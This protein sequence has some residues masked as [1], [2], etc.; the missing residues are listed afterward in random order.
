MTKMGLLACAMS[1]AWLL[2]SLPANAQLTEGFDDF[3][4]LVSPAGGWLV[5][6]NS[7]PV[8][9]FTWGQGDTAS[10]GEGFTSQS[11]ADN[12]FA[13][14]NFNAGGASAAVSDWLITPAITIQN[15]TIISFYTRESPVNVNDQTFPND[16]QVRLSLTGT[17][18]GSSAT[19]VGDFTTL[20]L[21]VNPTFSTTVTTGYPQ[22]WTRFNITISGVPTP[23]SGEI[24]FRYFL[25][26]NFT[27]GTGI[28]I[29][30][31][32]VTTVP[33]PSRLALLALGGLGLVFFK[34]REW[35]LIKR[36]ALPRAY[37][38]FTFIGRASPDRAGARPYHPAGRAGAC[39]ASRYT[40]IAQRCVSCLPS[41][42][43]GM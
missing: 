36:P 27:Q 17:D 22:N 33:E 40:R 12:S 11:G 2:S 1:I 25:Q 19:S 31:L 16:L 43:P 26:S 24:G 6:N 14:V 32:S 4:A 15:G 10:N 20:L 13:G 3:P 8:G 28:G 7:Q 5:I 23:T 29:D 37:G 18:V 35:R 9:D 42:R 21:D 38:L 41:H 30:T 39:P 34:L